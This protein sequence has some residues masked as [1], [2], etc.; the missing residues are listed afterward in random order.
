MK[1]PNCERCST[2]ME[3]KPPNKFWGCQDCGNRI[4]PPETWVMIACKIHSGGYTETCHLC[5]F[6]SR[7]HYLTTGAPAE[8]QNLLAAEWAQDYYARWQSCE[9]RLLRKKRQQKKGS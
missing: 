7:M 2:V 1:N 5:Q 4:Y 3:R 6:V 9:Q 8:D